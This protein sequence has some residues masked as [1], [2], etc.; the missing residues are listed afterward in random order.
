M[1]DENTIQALKKRY[2][3]IHPLMFHRSVEKAK[4]PGEL[5]DILDLFDNQYPVIWDEH[6]RRWVHT[7]DIFQSNN[8]GL[9]D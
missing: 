3:D 6:S 7:T 5:F 1:I 9:N 8:Y 2:P 4:T